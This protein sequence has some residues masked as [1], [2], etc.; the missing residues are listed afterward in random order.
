[1]KYSDNHPEA[2]AEGAWA[3]WNSEESATSL[4]LFPQRPRAVDTN[5]EL[6]RI[7]GR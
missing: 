1:M 5:E 6:V 2:R 7:S 3:T 4:H